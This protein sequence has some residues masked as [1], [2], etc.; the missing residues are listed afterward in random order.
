MEHLLAISLCIADLLFE[1]EQMP[2]HIV[3]AEISNEMKGL[4]A[5]VGYPIFFR[6]LLCLGDARLVFQALEQS[7]SIHAHVSSQPAD[8][9]VG[10]AEKVGLGLET[11]SG[12]ML[13]GLLQDSVEELTLELEA[14][15]RQIIVYI[16]RNR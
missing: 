6:N 3:H 16:L 8:L 11:V 2:L 10:M 1:I 12:I 14:I 5:E 13:H 9:L 7:V 15:S 4:V